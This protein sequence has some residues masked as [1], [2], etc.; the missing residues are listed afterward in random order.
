MLIQSFSEDSYEFAVSKEGGKPFLNFYKTNS[1][2]VGHVSGNVNLFA[3]IPYEFFSLI[4]KEFGSGHIKSSTDI[5]SVIEVAQDL[6]YRSEIF[7]K[8][9]SDHSFFLDVIFKLCQKLHSRGELTNILW[10]DK[11]GAD[12]VVDDYGAISFYP[13]GKPARGDSDFNENGKGV[14]NESLLYRHM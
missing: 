8:S 4:L 5:D 1:P 6:G 11:D 13:E 7:V 14:L 12:V 2:V 3:S 10:E 9:D